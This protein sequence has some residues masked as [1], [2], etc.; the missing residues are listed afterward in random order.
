MSL[1]LSDVAEEYIRHRRTAYTKATALVSDQTMRQFL[2]LV[3]NIQTRSL[4][5]RHAERFQSWLLSQGHKPNTINSR[6]SQ[7][8]NFS[9]WAQAHRYVPAH[10]VGTVRNIPVPRQARLRVPVDDFPRLLDAADRPDHRITVALG[11]FTFM[12][13]GDL[14]HRRVRDVDL[15]QGTISTIIQKTNDWD[16]K[17]ITWELDQELRRWFTAY[18]EDIGRPLHGSDFL[19]PAHRRFPGWLPRPDTGNFQ[20]DRMVLRP[21]QHVQAVLEKAG[22][23]VC[24]DGKKTSEG[25]H[26][27]RRS[28]ARA[29]YDALVD[30]RL[31]DPSARDDALR[32][33]MSALNHRTLATTEGYIGL[34]RD[35]QKRDAS[36]KG[37]RLIPLAP[38]N[39]INIKEAK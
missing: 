5:P 22:Y 27:L 6:M 25:V 28:G 35:R 32:Q 17:P 33:V 14:R 19:I 7:L 37:A 13:G 11:L 16:E 21:F 24:I 4:V 23:P 1:L 15:D 9:R 34:E 3:G 18:A 30:G 39:V 31:G 10:F 8:S 2:A 20:P 29:F 36:L 26:T 38:A 12:R